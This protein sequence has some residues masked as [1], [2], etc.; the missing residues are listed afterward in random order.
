MS[1]VKSRT[2]LQR[3][4]HILNFLPLPHGQGALRGVLSH[5]LF[6]T[7][8]PSEPHVYKVEGIGEDI[9]CDAMDYTVVDEFHQTN[10]KEAFTMARRLVM[11]LSPFAILPV[12][13]LAVRARTGSLVR[14]LGRRF[15]GHCLSVLTLLM[16]SIAAMA[17]PVNR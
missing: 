10:D 16:G 13:G 9:L 6:T 7:G 14:S 5:S 12:R 15:S 8:K 4:W 2:G 3:P 11:V 1:S 17:S